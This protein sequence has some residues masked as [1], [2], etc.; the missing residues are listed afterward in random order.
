MGWAYSGGHGL[1]ETSKGAAE[2]DG[3]GS[4]EDAGARCRGRDEV[5]G[6]SN[7]TRVKKISH[8]ILIS[9]DKDMT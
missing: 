2:G 8:D 7:V 4:N 9:C 6:F 3:G 1:G 5:S